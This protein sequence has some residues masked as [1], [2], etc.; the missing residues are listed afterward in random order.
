MATKDPPRMELPEPTATLVIDEGP[1]K[2]VEFDARLSLSPGPYFGARQ[3]IE[4]GVAAS[5]QESVTVTELLDPYRELAGIFAEYGL[6]KWNIDR[7]GEPIPA[8]LEGLLT[9]DARLLLQ[10]VR[11][12]LRSVGTVPIPL[13]G[14]SPRGAEPTARQAGKR[15]ASTASGPTGAS[16]P[17][18]LTAKTSAVSSASVQ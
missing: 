17:R 2:G 4:A 11:L 14:A 6:V 9:L 7:R 5:S 8:N 12:W 16:R 13:P 10:M 15:T 1:Y 3:W 18:R